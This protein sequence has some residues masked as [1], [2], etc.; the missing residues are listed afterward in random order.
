MQ[1]KATETGCSIK[2]KDA[3]IMVDGQ[4]K[5]GERVLPGPGEYEVS[6]VFAE[7]LPDV[8]VFHAEEMNIAYLGHG[9][10]KLEDREQEALE[11]VDVLLVAADS[12]AK[13]ELKAITD[14][15]NEIEPRI[16]VLTGV[17]DPGVFAKV[18]GQAPT[19]LDTLK[20]TRAD[21]PEEERLVYILTQ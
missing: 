18:E 13:D 19:S 21:L 2:T 4:M 16:L 7:V 8:A 6:G 17:K 11:A 10:K 9:K 12:D 3:V 5:I 20:V 1:I 15:A 14:L